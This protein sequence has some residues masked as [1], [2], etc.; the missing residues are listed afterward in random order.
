MG[1]DLEQRKVNY[2]DIINDLIT[3]GASVPLSAE[4]GKVSPDLGARLL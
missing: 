4:M 1:K 3:G 2:A